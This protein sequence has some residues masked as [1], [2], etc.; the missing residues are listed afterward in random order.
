MLTGNVSI[1]TPNGPAVMIIENG[2]LDL[3]TNQFTMA[4]KNDALTIVFTGKSGP[5]CPSTCYTHA[6]TDNGNGPGSSLDITAP[7]TGPWAG[8]ALI[9]D[10]NLTDPGLDVASAG[11]SPTWTITGL[12]YTPHATITLKGAI[13]KS[14]FGKSCVVMVADNFQIDG[15]GGILKTDIGQCQ[16]AGL[17]MPQAKVPGTALVL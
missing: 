6:P 3:N 12:I 11:N 7:T 9:Q 16:S 5:N 1:S 4:T 8:M 17:N 13:D 14:N 2:Q 15:T 10:P